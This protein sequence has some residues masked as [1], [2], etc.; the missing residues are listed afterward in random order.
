MNQR[1]HPSGTPGPGRFA[2]T[3]HAEADP[4]LEVPAPANPRTLPP[5]TRQDLSHLTVPS[6]DADAVELA[7]EIREQLRR[8]MS[9]GR[10]AT[11]TEAWAAVAADGWFRFRPSRCTGC[12]GRGW[13]PRTGGVCRECGGTRRATGSISVRARFPSSP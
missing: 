6:A 10:Y 4:T 9:T 7:D 3:P 1:R 11:W 12:R 5:L 2:A 13:D 8:A